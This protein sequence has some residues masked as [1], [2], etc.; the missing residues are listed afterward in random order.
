MRCPAGVG[1]RVALVECRVLV[2]RLGT[3]LCGALLDGIAATCCV[4]DTFVTASDRAHCEATLRATAGV[5][6]VI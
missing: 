2:L 6:Q 4:D 5:A 1:L 3:V